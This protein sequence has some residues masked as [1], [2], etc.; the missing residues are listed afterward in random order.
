MYIENKKFNIIYAD[1]PWQY[2]NGRNGSASRHYS[3]MTTEKICELP[4]QEL[5]VPDC[6]LFL[7][8][9]FPVLN[10]VF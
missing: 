10:E 7:W 2:K 6:V 1:P 3:L 9:T 8:V 4:I 5:A